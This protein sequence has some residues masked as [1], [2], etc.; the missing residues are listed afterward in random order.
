MSPPSSIG[1]I[2]NNKLMRT[3]IT[4]SSH[5]SNWIFDSKLDRFATRVTC[6]QPRLELKILL[7]NFPGQG[8]MLQSFLRP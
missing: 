5:Y 7:K 6:M 4:N 2:H 3:A 8:A 1:V